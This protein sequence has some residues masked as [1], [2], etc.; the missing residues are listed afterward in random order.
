[1][2]PHVTCEAIVRPGSPGTTLA[3]SGGTRWGFFHLGWVPWGRPWWYFPHL[4]GSP[5]GLTGWDLAHLRW[6]PSGRTRFASLRWAPSGKTRLPHFRWA[7]SGRTRRGFPHLRWGCYCCGYILPRHWPGCTTYPTGL[8]PSVFLIPLLLVASTTDVTLSSGILHQQIHRHGRGI[9][10]AHI[11]A[12][13][14]AK[15]LHIATFHL[16][17]RVDITTQAT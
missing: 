13:L 1:M 3:L 17:F 10:F 4:S 12:N 9:M 16:S 7:P 11:C 8:G 14:A 2:S 5:S 6:P 15:S